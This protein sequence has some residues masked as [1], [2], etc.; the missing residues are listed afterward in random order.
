[1]QNQRDATGLRFEEG[2]AALENLVAR[3]ESGDLPLEEA[4]RLFEEGVGLIRVLNEKLN[5]AERRI[6]VLSRGEDGAVRVRL[7][8]EDEQ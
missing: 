7:L 2:M 3:L 1:M 4:L 8:G 5:E 6:E